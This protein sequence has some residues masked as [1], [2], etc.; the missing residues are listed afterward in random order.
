MLIRLGYEIAI[1]CAEATPVISLLEI[2]K[3]RQADIK[4]QTRV[5]TSP[6]VPTRLYHD[7]YGNTCRRFTAPGGGFRILYDAVV[8]DSGE[9]DEVN[10]LAREV[11]VAELP[12]EVLC[13]LLGSRYCETDHLGG[14]AW[15][16]FGPV[17]SGWARVQAI[18]DYVHNRLSFGYGYAR[19]TRTAAQ[20]HEERVGVC[21]D[22]AHLAITLCRCMNI[23][24][25]YVNGY[26]GDI[27]V[28]LDPAPMD[29]SAWLEVFLDGKWYTFD[30]RHNM[31][32]IGRIVI[33]RGRDATDV[34]LLHSFGPHRLGLFKVWTYEQESNLFNPPHR[35]VDRTV[36][37]QML[38]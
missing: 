35:G 4:R 13:Y 1:D 37:A 30:P 11:P 34:P 36:S 24:A 25:R 23:P 18:V 3:E 6:A 9:A 38:A 21:R 33:A 12:D 8:E 7:L 2:H 14:L 27:G 26:L 10:L 20:A 16:V 17:P 31:P 15:Q 32:R 22:F 19:P 28:P 29:F 5:L